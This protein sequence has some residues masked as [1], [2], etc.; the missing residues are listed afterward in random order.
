[1]KN[2]GKPYEALTEVVFTRLLAQDNVCAKV[3]RDVVLEGRATKHQVDVTFE[4]VAGP[5]NY[6]TIIQCKDWGSAVKQEQVLAFHSVLADIPGQPR[7]IMVSRSGF[8]E[9]ARRVAD[10]NG[11]K[12]YELREPRDEDWE[13]LI[14]TFVIKMHL[15]APR[16]EDVR[17]VFDEEAIR[18][19]VKARSLP[20]I[21]VTF[22]GPPDLTPVVFEATGERCD[23]NRILNK[24]VPKTGTDPVQVRHQFSEKV[25]TEVPGSPIP[26]LPLKG[27][28]ATIHVSEHEDEMRVNIDH[29][30]AYCFKDVIAGEVRFLAADGGPIHDREQG[31]T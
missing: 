13:G 8:Q 19:E 2:T 15:R 6:R 10:H 3:E 11:I 9:G 7:G 23:L 24:L 12:L 22:S 4:F 17:L 31:D 29:L 30:I 14:R 5:V 28:E 27:I 25:V 26:R 20:G 21:N 16:F 18:N 1:V